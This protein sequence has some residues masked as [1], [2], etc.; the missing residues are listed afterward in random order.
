MAERRA[1]R[2]STSKASRARH[3]RTRETA[4]DSR[5]RRKPPVLS[6]PEQV[7]LRKLQLGM[8]AAQIAIAMNCMKATA[9]RHIRSIYHKFGAKDRSDL[10]NVDETGVN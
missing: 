7:V 8:S 2:Q 6:F 10:E 9:D 3:A 4:H 5:R 1:N